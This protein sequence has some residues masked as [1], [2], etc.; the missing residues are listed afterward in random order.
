[1]K[2]SILLFLAILCSL[3]RLQAQEGYSS[4]SMSMSQQ[5][6]DHAVIPQPDEIIMEEY[7]NYHRH[8]IPLPKDGMS[9]ALDTRWGNAKVSPQ[10][11][12]AILQIGLTTGR[13]ADFSE[14]NPVNVS[15]VIDKSGSMHEDNKLEKT[16]DAMLAFVQKLREQDKVSIVTFDH[17]ATVVLEAQPASNIKAIESAIKNIR[18]GGSTNMYDGIVMGYE[19]ILKNYQEGR[20]NRIIVLTDAMTNTGIVDPEQM[21]VKSSKY[22]KDYDIDFAMIGVGIDFNNKLTR[23]IADNGKNQIHFI[24]NADDIKKI[25]IDEVGAILYPV[26]KDPVLKITFEEGMELEQLYG[27][28][29]SYGENKITI[30]LNKMNAGLT[31]VVMAKF[32]VVNPTHEHLCLRTKLTYYDITKNESVVLNQKIE[33]TPTNGWNNESI[34]MLTDLE[35]KK[36]YRIAEMALCLKKW[37]KLFQLIKLVLPAKHLTKIFK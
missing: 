17:V 4:A 31:Q 10:S 18:L 24:H 8:N 16:K 25:F 5:K 35:V 7:I 23:Q 2:N 34:D 12:E 3:Q 1:M 33:L 29:P 13:I 37:P 26:A 22:H 32:K 9:V 27:Y 20:T 19:E 21:I 36:N 15:L 11:P 30:H 6:C 14:S 28:Q